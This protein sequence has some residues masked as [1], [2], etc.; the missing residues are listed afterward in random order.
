VAE[1]AAKAGPVRFNFQVKPVLTGKCFACHGPDEAE[2]KGKLRL[3]VRESALERNF[4]L[5]PWHTI[6][7]LKFLAPEATLLGAEPYF[8]VP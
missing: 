2:R 6:S 8:P 5:F 3:D 1:E 7:S 4:H